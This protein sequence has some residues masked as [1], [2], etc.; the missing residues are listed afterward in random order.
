MDIEKAIGSLL[1]GLRDDTSILLLDCPKGILS[2]QLK[3]FQHIYLVK[4]DINEL[5]FDSNSFGLI[6][7]KS[8]MRNLRMSVKDQQKI[9]KTIFDILR[10]DGIFCLGIENK[11]SPSFFSES[12]AFLAN[13]HLRLRNSNSFWGSILQFILAIKYCQ[14]HLSFY[15]RYM[16]FLRKIGFKDASVYG[17]PRSLNSPC[18]ISLQKYIYGYFSQSLNPQRRGFKK[19]L[20]KLFNTLGVEKFFCHSYIL[21]VRKH[22]A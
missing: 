11:I 2:I 15:W 9:F 7:S 8:I 3:P 19:L 21:I 1:Y 5:P 10:P 4:A 22:E 16:K 20:N 17:A 13:T 14:G 6:V 18:V 12:K